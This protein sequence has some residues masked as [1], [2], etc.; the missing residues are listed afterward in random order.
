[1]CSSSSRRVATFEGSDDPERQ[2]REQVD[3]FGESGRL[4]Y[5]VTEL[6][7]ARNPVDRG[8]VRLVDRRRGLSAGHE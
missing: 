1:M 2:M 8:R 4:F 7:K 3:H 5:D 6:S